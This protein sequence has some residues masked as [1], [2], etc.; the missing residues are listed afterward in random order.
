MKNRL[1]LFIIAAALIACLSVAPAQA[2]TITFDVLDTF[3]EVGENFD[4]VV[5]ALDETNTLGDLFVFGFNVDP[6]ASLTL[7][8]FDSAYVDSDYTDVSNPPAGNNVSGVLNLGVSNAG[9]TMFHLQL[10]ISLQALHQ[11]QTRFRSRG[12][13]MVS[14]WAFIMKKIFL[15]ILETYSPR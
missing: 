10:L 13:G 9:R 1:I 3:I 4:V 7:F 6:L 15:G 11:E 8:S 12:Y 14:I 5:S 2:V